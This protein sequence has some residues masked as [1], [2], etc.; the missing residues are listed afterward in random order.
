MEAMLITLARWSRSRPSGAH[1]RSSAW[2]RKNGAFRL[3]STTLSQPLSGNSSYG[4]PQAAP[5]LLTRMS[6]ELSCLAI[7]VDQGLRAFERGDIGRQRDAVA[8]RRREFLRGWSQGVRLARRDVDPRRALAPEKPSAIMRPMPR[9]PP[10]TRAVRP[11]SENESLIMRISLTFQPCLSP[12]ARQVEQCSGSCQARP[13][14]P[15]QRDFQQG[16]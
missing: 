6:S 5:A 9:D 3:R 7:G 11:F 4:A 14:I 13:A 1:R 8:R 2:V 15:L 12:R 16:R 10:V